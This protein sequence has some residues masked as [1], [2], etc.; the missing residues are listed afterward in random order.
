MPGRYY[1]D[2]GDAR[3]TSE[4]TDPDSRKA[5]AV[6]TLTDSADISTNPSR[7]KKNRTSEAAAALPSRPRLPPKNQNSDDSKD[8]GA[9]EEEEE[10]ERK[11]LGVRSSSPG[12]SREAAGVRGLGAGWRAGRAGGAASPGA[13]VRPGLPRTGVAAPARGAL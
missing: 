11:T 1:R 9:K 6:F 5:C 12:G 13:R 2:L 3:A 10:E 8:H 4:F 7:G